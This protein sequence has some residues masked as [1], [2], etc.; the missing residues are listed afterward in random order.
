MFCHLSLIL[1]FINDIGLL[2]FWWGCFLGPQMRH[3][4]V[5]RLGVELE[6]HLPGYTTAIAV[7]DSGRESGPPPQ[8]T[9]TPD[10]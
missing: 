10:P 5:P 9:A 3:M 8:L 6:L 4:E 2:F 7:K 1:T